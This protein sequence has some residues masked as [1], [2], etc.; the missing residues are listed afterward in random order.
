MTQVLRLAIAIAAI[1][2]PAASA[3]QYPAKPVRM[4]NINAPGGPIDILGRVVSERLA[5][6]LGQPFITDNRPSAVGT[7]AMAAGM[8]APADGYTMLFG[9]TF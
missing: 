9:S 5:A 6:R 3:Q 4:I 2:S 8:T 1:G 7:V